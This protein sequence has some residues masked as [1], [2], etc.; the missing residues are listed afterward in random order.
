MRNPYQSEAML[1]IDGSP[2]NL[3]LTLGAL[4]ALEDALGLASLHD[5]VDRFASN[6]F[7]SKDLIL[8][9]N[10]GLYGAGERVSIEDVS[11]KG[12]AIEAAKTAMQLLVGAFPK[13]I[14]NNAL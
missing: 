2:V 4:A 1:V 11:I 3:K 7:S 13:D 9:L 14:E 10:A 12:G 6:A 5:L 8:V